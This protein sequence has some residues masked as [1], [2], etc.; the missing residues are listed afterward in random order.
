VRWL[1]DKFGLSWQMFP[2]N[3]PKLV[4]HPKAIQA[5]LSMKKLNIAELES[6]RGDR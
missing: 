4:K 2:A 5:M 3:L 6:A 1:K